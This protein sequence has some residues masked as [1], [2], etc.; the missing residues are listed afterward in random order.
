M[1]RVARPR[2]ARCICVSGLAI[3]IDFAEDG[4]VLRT[5]GEGVVGCDDGGREARLKDGV[6]CLGVKNEDI[7][8]SVLFCFFCGGCG[9]I[10]SISSVICFWKFLLDSLDLDLSWEVTSGVRVQKIF[11]CENMYEMMEYCLE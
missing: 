10:T 8:K 9:G 7:D 4:G 2:L 3:G 1:V 11:V 5:G 6:E